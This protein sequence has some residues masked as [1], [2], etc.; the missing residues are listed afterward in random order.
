MA[1]YFLP[2]SGPAFPSPGRGRG[3]GR[4]EIDEF[5]TG[6]LG[7]STWASAHPV[8]PPRGVWENFSVP[9]ASVGSPS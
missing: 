2:A 7:Q 4:Q 9:R 1:S 5:R 6:L 3:R 8:A